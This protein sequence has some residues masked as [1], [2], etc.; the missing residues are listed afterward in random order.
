MSSGRRA[1]ACQAGLAQGTGVNSS[2]AWA[3]LL[4]RT[5]RVL[6]CGFG[7]EL[8]ASLI[9]GRSGS[10][11]DVCSRGADMGRFARSRVVELARVLTLEL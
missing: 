1:G 3:L 7:E 4:E 5:F 9:A 2:Q 6:V 11:G 8:V 10:V